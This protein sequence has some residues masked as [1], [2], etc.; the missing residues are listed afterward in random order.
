MENW[1]MAIILLVLA[2]GGLCLYFMLKPKRKW[3]CKDG[4]CEVV[5][6]GDFESEQKCLQSCRKK[7]EETYKK[8]VHFAK[9][10]TEIDNNGLVKSTVISK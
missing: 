8:K 7:Q 9:K 10:R 1:T 4:G 5:I 3:S 2:I 6:N